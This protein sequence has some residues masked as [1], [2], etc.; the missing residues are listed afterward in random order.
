MTHVGT[1]GG[2]QLARMLALAGHPLGIELV[3]LDPAADAGAGA[4]AE[5]LVGAYDD[6]ALLD[7]LA[8]RC[9]VVTFEFESVPA[10]SA[11]RLAARTR[12]APP[13]GALA[14]CQD[15]LAE[16]RLFERLGIACAAFAPLDSAAGAEAAAAHTGLP[17]LAKTRRGG[18][19]G[20][21]QLPVSSPREAAAAAERL[22]GGPLLLEQR[23]AFRRELSLLAVRSLAGELRF[24]P[25]VEN[26]HRDGILRLTLAPAPGLDPALQARAEEDARRLLEELD[27]AG[28]LAI[29]LFERDGG[30]A[31]NELAPRVHNSGHWTIEGAETSQFENHLRA[32]TGLPLG[33]TGA[34]CPCAMVNLIG[35]L[36]ERDAVLAVPGAHL[37]LYAKAP[38]PGRK[39][40]HV[41][42]LAADEDELRR[43]LAALAQALP[44]LRRDAADVVA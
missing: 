40:G 19:D 4:A 36:P 42:V 30:L 18:Y 1:L 16:K 11:E 31:A 26:R 2:G 6:P 5:L 7:R 13:Q 37:H 38:R 17:A 21:G 22:G 3:A 20:K 14:V 28:V 15:R 10:A 12:V 8:E 41:T 25:L 29:E 39:L 23:L 34:R 44:E 33:L 32:V 43:R 9:D 35:E 24:Y 27:Y